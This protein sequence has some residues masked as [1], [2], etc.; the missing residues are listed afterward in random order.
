M[1]KHRLFL[2]KRTWVF[3]CSFFFVSTLAAQ[4]LTVR[5][6]VTDSGKQPVIGATII[7]KND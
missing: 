2:L 4:S 6:M 7:V 3:L 5:G 1:E